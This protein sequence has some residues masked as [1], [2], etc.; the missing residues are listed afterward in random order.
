M[1]QIT[2]SNITIDIVRKNIQNLHLAVYP[3]TG[4]VRIAAPLKIDDEAVRLFAISKLGWIKKHRKNFANQQR[5]TQREYVSGESH[6]F[7]GGRYL[8]N[9]IYQNAKPKVLIRN[10]TYIDL[11]VRQDSNLKQRE[12]VMTECY[13]ERL[14]E[15]I[16]PFIEK[17]QKKI[18]VDLKDWQVK[19]MRT[20]WGTCN[21]EQRRIWLNLELAKK[22]LHCLEYIIVHELVHFL[23]RHHNDR[24]VALMDKFL[25]NWRFCQSELNRLI[26]SYEDWRDDIINIET[27]NTKGIV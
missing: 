13:R 14:K 24:Y 12:K 7:E 23:E 5:E 27:D 22:P 2:V 21:I 1:H 19:R 10:K 11:Y 25:P 4:R 8:L 26:L 16:Q 6:Y 17:W 20:K 3:P 18:G 9:V 15:N